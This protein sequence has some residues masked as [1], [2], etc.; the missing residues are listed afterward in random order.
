MDAVDQGKFDIKYYPGKENLGNNQSKH[1]IGAPHTAVYP[2]FLH[3]L[4]SVRELPRASKPST[5][6]GCVVTLTETMQSVPK[7][8]KRLPT[9]FE[10]PPLI[11]VL[12]RAIGPAIARAR[13]PW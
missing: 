7:K 1:H 2:W 10:I 8:E 11:P 3:K 5:L 12:R 4:T 13:T 6:K 9:Y